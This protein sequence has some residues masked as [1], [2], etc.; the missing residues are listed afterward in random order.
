MKWFSKVALFVLAIGF[1][2]VLEAAQ[3]PIVINGK[4]PFAKNKELRFYTYDDLLSKNLTYE[5]SATVNENGLFSVSFS[6][7][8][9]ITMLTINY[10]LTYGSIYVEPGHTYELELYTDSTLIDRVDAEMLGNYIQINCL[11]NDS[12][13]LNWKLNYFDQYYTY[14]MYYNGAAIIRH[15]PKTVYDSLLNIIKERFPLSDEAH[16]FYSVYVRY[17]I[18]AIESLYFDKSKDKVF[19]KYL[20]TPYVYYE[21]PAYMD[22]IDMFFEDYLYSGTQ[23]ITKA[24]LYQDINEQNNYYKLLDDLGKDPLL[25]N[26]IIRELVLIKGLWELR[27]YKDE[28][29]LENLESMLKTLARKTKFPEHRQIAD[30]QLKSFKSLQVGSRFPAFDFVDIKGNHVTSEQYK[31]KYLYMQFFTTYC[32]DC[33]REMLIL[34]YLHETYGDRVEFLSVM[35]DFEPVHLY[36]FVN[37]HSEF[38]WQFVHFGNNFDFI[39]AYKPYSLPL[40]MLVDPSGKIVVYPA[41]FASDGLSELFANIFSK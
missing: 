30:D 24:M 36:H 13:E 38:N 35:L 25:K 19:K 11:N 9:E 3:Q 33:I 16:D 1:S 23:K 20:E 21:N 41:P 5:K 39:D 17:K 14:F 8:K 26:E 27:A 18:A 2:F 32:Q 31:G 29:K 6:D 28:F 37:N 7:I 12:N 34:K 22:F 40:G 4:A 10:N 15:A